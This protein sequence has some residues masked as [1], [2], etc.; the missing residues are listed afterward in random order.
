MERLREFLEKVRHGGYAAGNFL[1]L[2]HVAIGRRIRT[3]DGEEVS[4]G[5]SWRDLAALLKKLRWSPDA[6]R[7]LGLDPD[8]LPPRDRQR[9]WYLAISQAG[10][11]SAQ[12]VE[13]GDRL[14]EA[15]AAAGYTVGPAPRA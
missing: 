10:V 14:A 13:A 5:L 9:F 7:E 3:A 4:S 15:V 6:V 11:A 8:A 12:A 1:G 2:L